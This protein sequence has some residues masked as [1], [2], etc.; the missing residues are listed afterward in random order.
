MESL[1]TTESRDNAYLVAV[2][3]GDQAAA[4]D[5]LTEQA[6]M[7]GFNPKTVWHGTE[8][9]PFVEF[10][11]KKVGCMTGGYTGGFWFAG[12]KSAAEHY[13]SGKELGGRTMECYLKMANHLEVT[14][15]MFRDNYPHGP[16]F[17][18]K[19]AKANRCDGVVIRDIVDGDERGD[20]FAVWIPEHIKIADSGV[21][22]SSGVVVPLSHRFNTQTADI[23]GGASFSLGGRGVIARPEPRIERAI[24]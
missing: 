8:K 11:A 16:G 9:G 3:T 13:H 7:A 5:L 18:A 19:M 12:E 15:Q 1:K 2:A 14:E 6:Q 21:C 24:V 4:R 10:D 23:R 17:W 22:D 20:V